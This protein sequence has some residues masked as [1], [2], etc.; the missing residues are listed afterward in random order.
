MRKIRGKK[1]AI[2]MSMTTIIVIVLSLTLLIFGFV[3]VR[4]IMC[5]AIGLTD[6]VGDKAKDEINKLFGATSGEV[7]CIGESGSPASMTPGERNIIFCGVRAE[8]LQRYRFDI[9]VNRRSSSQVITEFVDNWFLS[10]NWDREVA[11]GDEEAKK[12]AR[13]DLPEDAPEGNL[14]FDLD[15]YVDGK[16]KYAKTLDYKVTR[17]GLVRSAIC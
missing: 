17:L 5:T 16:K 13:L 1:A 4:S 6:S 14:V 2:E 15:V 10:E 9:E 8:Q 7:I 3:F 11:P 12:I